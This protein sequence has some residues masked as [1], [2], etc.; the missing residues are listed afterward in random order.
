MHI[1]VTDLPNFFTWYNWHSIA[2]EPQLPIS[3]SLQTLDPTFCSICRVT[4]ALLDFPGPNGP[5]ARA[6]A[7]GC[8][9]PCWLHTA[10][11]TVLLLKVYSQVCPQV[12]PYPWASNF[13]LFAG[14]QSGAEITIPVIWNNNSIYPLWHMSYIILGITLDAWQIWSL[15]LT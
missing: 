12:Q 1:V 10:F 3:L 11:I 13:H 9:A 4:K 2:M 7:K 8:L 14:Y 5:P 15:I 6:A